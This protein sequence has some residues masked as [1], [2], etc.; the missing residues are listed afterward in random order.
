VE[1]ERVL[2]D[3]VDVLAELERDRT[4]LDR[5]STAE[6]V[7]DVLRDRI[8]AGSF[9]PGTRLSEDRITAALGVSRNTLREAFRLLAHDRLVVHELN[10]GVFV[11]RLTAADLVDLYQVRRV[12]ESAAL[13]LPAP[14]LRRVAAAVEQ[15]EQAAAA[16][17][18][19]T[20]ATADL[21]FHCE[22]AALA[23]SRRLDELMRRVVAELRLAFH[24]MDDAAAFHG[25][26]LRRNRTI[27]RL[28]EAG[29]TDAAERELHTYLDEAER[30]LL[31]SF[32]DAPDQVHRAPV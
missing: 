14:D 17:D 12:V 5:A 24:V 20:V 9:P 21:R 10:R 32:Q 30:Q 23:R 29:R 18:W 25:P 11:R 22:L 6:R 19:A 3:D 7:A 26:Y 15:G 13:R 16:D 31:G 27:L 1:Q 8:S 4:R 28:L 2:R